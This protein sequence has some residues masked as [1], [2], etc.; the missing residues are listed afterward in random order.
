MDEE[1][2][3][4]KMGGLGRR[5]PTT[6]LTFWIGSLAL[7]GIPVFAGFFSKD[8][9]LSSA[10][11]RALEDPFYWVIFVGLEIA[12]FLTAFY[13]GRACFLTFSGAPRSEKAAH[14]HESPRTMTV[15]LVILA[16]FALL[17]GWIGT[18]LVLGNWFH[19][20]IGPIIEHHGAAAHAPH[21]NWAAAGVSM[22][23]AF[24]GL[25]L[26]AAIYRWSLVPVNLLKV[27]FYPLY[28]AARRKFFFDEIYHYTAV[29]GTLLA[30]QLCRLIDTYV[31]D[32]AVNAVGWLSAYVMT[33]VVRVVDTYLVDGAVNL[34]GWITLN[35]GGLL[36][37]TQSGRI[38]EYLTALGVL[39]AA[40]AV[41]LF[42][43]GLFLT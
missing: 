34:V 5:M 31:I 36:R 24:S 33:F 10:W 30:A 4:W 37:R 28:W 43:A 2:D 39:A 20:L 18:P 17:L 11:A 3:M 21:F 12:A 26:A 9:I 38:Q 8:E 41:A 32:F 15:P 13:I 1:Q 29:A 25:A 35:V 19:H 42:I 27:P 7:A 22:L 14:A 16:V 6:A 40:I 23:M